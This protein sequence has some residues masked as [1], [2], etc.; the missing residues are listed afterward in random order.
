APAMSGLQMVAAPDTADPHVMLTLEGRPRLGP[1]QY[2]GVEGVAVY[3]VDQRRAACA[4]DFGGGCIS[5]ERRQAQAIGRPN[6]FDNILPVGSTTTI[7]GVTI[8]V[9][10]KTG[11]AFT[12][13]TS[14]TFVAPAPLPIGGSG[15]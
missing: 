14:G 5:T 6:T 10:G 11:N 4:A 8:I 15:G 9:S 13:Q 1:D 2:F 3:L 7:D 12:V